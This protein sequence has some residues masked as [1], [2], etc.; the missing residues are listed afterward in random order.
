MLNAFLRSSQDGCI[1]FGDYKIIREAGQGANAI[2]SKVRH[3]ATDS[4]RALKMYCADDLGEEHALKEFVRESKSATEMVHPNIVRVFQADIIGD[5]PYVVMEFV[6][7]Y[8]MAQL[9]ERYGPLEQFDVLAIMS[10]VMDALDY[11]WNSFLMIHRDVKPSNILLDK[12]GNVKVF[13][14]GLVTGHESAAV[15]LDVIEGTPYYLSPESLIQGSHLDNRSDLY[16]SGSTMYHLI[17]GVPPFD[18]ESLDQVV[19]ARLTEP[20]PDLREVFPHAHP[21][22]AAIIK[23]LMQTKPEDRYSTAAEA[24]QDID[25]VLAGKN[26][27]L[28]GN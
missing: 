10:Y 8:D 11:V 26:P 27:N 23:T 20:V 7:G 21:D 28:V 18:Y 4:K 19:N 25:L 22:V 12:D 17:A 1:Y 13:D 14:F 9:M 2:I 15:D 6:T 3:M 5:V 24:K 16:A